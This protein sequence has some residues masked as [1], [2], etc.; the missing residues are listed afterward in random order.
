MNGIYL[1]LVLKEI[2]RLIINKFIHRVSAQDRLIQVEFDDDSL[3]VSLYPQALGLYIGNKNSKFLKL[4]VFDEHLEG[5]HIT[6]IQQI[7]FAP[8]VDLFLERVEYGQRISFKIRLSFYKEGPNLSLFLDKTRRDLFLRYIEKTP[9]D[10]IFNVTLPNL[11]SKELLIKNFEGIDKSLAQELN[12]GTL[13]NLKNIIN[14][15]PHKPRVISIQPLKISLFADKFIREYDSWNELFKEEITFYVEQKNKISIENKTKNAIIKIEQKIARLKKEIADKEVVEFYRIAG[16]LIL[17]NISKIKKGMEKIKLFDPYSQKDIEIKLNPVK[18]AY[19]NAEEY[20][21]KYKK[22]KRGIPKIE[23]RIK[24]LEKEINLL[25]SGVEIKKH[26]SKSADAKLVKEK[27]TSPFRE[28]VLDSG[29]HIYVGKDARTNMELT[30]KFAQPDDYFFHI[31]GY[32]GAHTILRPVLK[33]GQNVR[34]DDIEK[35]AAIAAYFSKAKNQKNIPVSYTQR[36]YLKKS[37]K[38]KLGSVILMRENVIFVDPAL[39]SDAQD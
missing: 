3:F 16:E 25:K 23:E 5:V 27:K 36:K 13:E 7:G 11:E 39:P 30:F 15:A 12:Q 14:G 31:R 24:K 10:S 26:I 6:H 34:K 29:S 2:S 9:K 32:E 22:M 4:N 17:M 28:F 20:F 8:V 38:G 33:K 1:H 18:D 21:K 35:A 19:K 37:K